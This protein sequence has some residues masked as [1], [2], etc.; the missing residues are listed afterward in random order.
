MDIIDFLD[1]SYGMCY[2]PPNSNRWI[3][4]LLLVGLLGTLL[5]K[6]TG[7]DLE[8]IRRDYLGLN[9]ENVD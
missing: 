8:Q 1:D 5:I 7:A 6:R 4:T 3:F 2:V 9:D